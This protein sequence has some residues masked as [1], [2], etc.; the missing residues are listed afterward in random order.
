ME[1]HVK[2]S[3]C[4]QKAGRLYIV[5]SDTGGSLKMLA[6]A[7]ACERVKVGDLLSPLKDAQYC[8]NRDTSRVIKIIDARQYLCEEWERLRQ[9]S[10]DK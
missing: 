6:E 1:W 4:N 7:Q 2:K 9:L 3:C 10:D 5:L 8:I